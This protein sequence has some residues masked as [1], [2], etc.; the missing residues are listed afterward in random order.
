MAINLKITNKTCLKK[1]NY[2]REISKIIEKI[3]GKSQ[4]PQEFGE[5]LAIS[6]EMPRKSAETLDS[7]RAA[8]TEGVSQQENAGPQVKVE[9]LKQENLEKPREKLENSLQNGGIPQNAARQSLNLANYNMLLSH[10]FAR[11]QLNLM[12]Y[13]NF[14]NFASPFAFPGISPRAPQQWLDPRFFAA[15]GLFPQNFQ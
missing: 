2:Y 12:N 11:Q 8:L 9:A 1:K 3:A 5:E 10:Q 6:R 13:S 4:K 14:A 7:S 15:A